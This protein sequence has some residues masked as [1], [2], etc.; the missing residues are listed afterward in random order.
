[1]INIRVIPNPINLTRSL[2]AVC[3]IAASLLLS[4]SAK[5]AAA[6]SS[7]TD[8]GVQSVGFRNA[9]LAW[10]APYDAAASTTP[11]YYQI[12]V[13]SYRVIVDENDWLAHSTSS[14]FPYRIQFATSTTAGILEARVISGLINTQ[15]Y[16]F[17]IKSSTDGVNW[18]A[19]DS[20]S[21][22]PQC[23]PYNSVPGNVSGYN[24]AG[25]PTQ[26]VFT[27][28]PT[29]SWSAVVN[30]GNGSKD[31]NY[32]DFI[33]S[34][35]LWYSTMANFSI[36]SVVENITQTNYVTPAL[37]ENTTFY[38][39]V[40]AKDSEGALSTTILQNP[41]FAVNASSQSPLAPN[42]ISPDDNFIETVT[43]MPTFSWQA[44]SDPDP[45]DYVVYDF[46]ISTSAGFETAVTTVS[47]SITNLF[48]APWWELAENARYFWKVHARDTSGL[49]TSSATRSL[50]INTGN[51]SPGTFEL[52]YPTSGVTVLTSSPTLSWRPSVDP[53]PLDT[54][55][56]DINYSSHDPTLSQFFQ[57]LS[58]AAT[59]YKLNGLVED[60]P[61]WWRAIARDAGGLT[62]MSVSI[63]S[64]VVNEFNQPPSAFALIR[65]SGIAKTVAPLF[66]WEVSVDPDPYGYVIYS[67]YISSRA[68]FLFYFS[69]SGITS[70]SYTS[71]P[72]LAENTTYWWYVVARDPLD[73]ATCSAT[74][75]VV[76]N[77]VDENP[78]GLSLV[79]P[80][81]GAFVP[82]LVP[83]LEW[84][85]ASDPDPYDG[86]SHYALEYSTRADFS[87]STS[88]SPLNATYYTFVSPLLNHTT[89]YWRVS[90]VSVL[91]GVSTTTA[92][93]FTVQN[94]PP[95]SFALTSPSGIIS[96]DT[97]RFEW[98]AAPDP[99]GENVFYDFY[100]S[101]AEHFVASVSSLSIP[102][103]YYDILTLGD[104][105]KYW[106]KV[107]ARNE[108]GSVSASSTVYFAVNTA[109]EYPSAFSLLAPADGAVIET[110]T[111]L[112]EWQGSSDPDPED[113]VVY[114]LRYSLND[115]A[116]YSPTEVPGISSLQY[117]IAPAATLQPDATYYWRVVARDMTGRET[118]AAIRGFYVKPS[119]RP[120]APAAFDASYDTAARVVALTWVAPTL[121]TDGTPVGNLS[122][123]LIYRA[124][125]YDELYAISP[126]SSVAAPTDSFSA[127]S[128]I[129]GAYFMLRAVSSSGVT[130]ELSN[131]VRV[132][133]EITVHYRDASGEVR[134]EGSRN[135]LP[136]SVTLYISEDAPDGDPKTMRAF[137][138]TAR[139]SRGGQIKTFS[140]PVT[141]SV[142]LS[143]SSQNSP[144]SIS[145]S[146]PAVS[147]A[148]VPSEAIYWFN[149]VEWVSLG[150]AAENGYLAA[151]ITATGSFR[152]RAVERSS[153]FRMLNVWPKV[154]TPNA[155]GANDEL[156]M[157]FENPLSEKAEGDIFDITGFR[158]GRM[159][160]KTDSWSAWDGKDEGGRAVPAGIYIYQLKVG[161]AVKNG[162]VVVAR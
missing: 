89:Y 111:P 51:D 69:S 9:T 62:A 63:S 125:N 68:D 26:V 122:H 21:P 17:G 138:L 134:V 25:T 143:A 80:T 108:T 84:T 4:S 14:G 70:A 120:M 19:V 32:G 77:A 18:S 115:P 132:G 147:A 42:L 81:G 49:Q 121:N 50:W 117:Q 148:S 97:P 31:N 75:F 110:Q 96:T 16:F 127:S 67:I 136:S 40:Y 41:Q 90:A 1:M 93:S 152:I 71:P 83:R 5:L 85:A 141:L 100:L 98:Q 158:V 33:A 159:T 86:I 157:T 126:S 52:F 99:Q 53:D 139:D 29:L 38:W 43:K 34:Y 92:R 112:F 22:E 54:L 142:K 160:S 161:S 151:K 15:T 118:A 140:S 56:Y 30:T 103:T 88:V 72:S 113:A 57:A 24:Y 130:G 10:T 156:N 114:I 87:P 155:D 124:Y 3:A 46:Y 133:S 58:V 59:F 153:S 2:A 44:A 107:S 119:V 116:L 39:G 129:S 162:T 146:R 94:L 12:R 23:A 47:V 74:W 95:A 64:F 131:V 123:Y 66:E 76:I 13:S 128:V 11:A 135:E 60:A 7:V 8:L 102:T 109:P 55:T 137:N 145:V 36:K 82:T 35:T 20:A 78:Q 61:Y 79:S 149:G 48:W 6:P 27:S 65:S 144:N 101:T 28:T 91:T 45:G 106:W 150:G 154:V 105:A 37:A 104:N 73:L